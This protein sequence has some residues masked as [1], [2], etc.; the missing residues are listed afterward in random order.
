MPPI[1]TTA[2]PRLKSHPAE[3][4]L[5]RLYTPTPEEHHLAQTATKG[6]VARL[7][8]LLLLKTVQRLGY[9]CLITT[10]PDTIVDHL[11]TTLQ[12]PLT[13]NDLSTYDTSGTRS[14]HIQILRHHLNIHPYDRQTERQLLRHLMQLA[15][16]KTDLTDLI[17]AG[18]EEL[19]R[20]RSEL[21]SF[22]M[23]ERTAR[24]ARAITHRSLYRT[25]L[26]TFDADML[27]RFDRLLF[28]GPT[29]Q[30]T[31]W[32]M[33]KRDPGMPTLQHLQ[34]LLDHLG[35]LQTLPNVQSLRQM[36]PETKL[37]HFADEAASLDAGRLATVM[38][39]KRYTL[40]ATYIIV[41][42]AQTYDDLTT[43]FI[44]RMQSIHR[45]AHETWSTF[46][47]SQYAEA[48][49]LI[50]T[51]RNVVLAYQ[52]PGTT[53]ARLHAIADAFHLQP[54]EIL[55]ACDTQLQAMGR[56]YYP[57]MWHAYRSHRSALFRLLHALPLQ[58]TSQHT[59]FLDA[60]TFLRT[61]EQSKGEW[62]TIYH[63]VQ[64]D[65]G[66]RYRPMISLD[67]MTDGWW[68]LVTKHYTHLPAPHTVHR[69]HFEV[70]IFAHLLAHLQSGD[71]AVIGS[72]AYRD[73]RTQ[74]I[75]WDEYHQQVADYGTMLGFPTT[76]SAFIQHLQTILTTQARTTDAAFPALSDVR[77]E[78]GEPVV[79]RLV[80]RPDPPT[81]ASL[82]T[83]ITTHLQPINILELL[84]LTERWLHWSQPFGL[85]S[86]HD[87]KLDDARSR[88]V[89]TT[90]CY[91]CN[92]GP[93]QTARGMRGLD[94]KQIAW[95]NQRHI[96]EDDLDAAIR[97]IVDA[98]QHLALPK[99]WGSGEHVS[100]DG[101]KWDLYEQNLVAEYHIRYGGYGGIGYYHVSDTYI[102]LFS[103]F[104]PCG[105][106]EAVYILD[107][108]L[109]NESSL[110]P[111]ILHA[112]TQGQ[113]APV[114]AL[115]W[116]LGITLMPRIRNW[117]HLTFFRSH[118][119]EHYEHIDAL[120]STA[121]NW[122]LIETHVPDM[123]RVVLSMQAGK[124]TPSTMLRRLSSYNQHNR[125][126]QSFRELGRVIRTIFLLQYLAD[127][128]LRRMILVALNKGESYHHFLQWL[129]FG[130]E[131][132]IATNDRLAQRK[133]IKY[134]HLV[135]NCTIFYTV[136]AMSHALY[137]L[138][139]AGTPID[140]EALACLSPY[141][142]EHI[143]RF[144]QYPTSTDAEM[145]AFD[146]TIV[147]GTWLPQPLLRDEPPIIQRRRPQPL[148]DETQLRFEL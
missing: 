102:A 87:T 12:I 126:Y 72:E 26:A 45:K 94:R 8:F 53:D 17:N 148:S 93:V 67:W 83:A 84:R 68:R 132:V 29:P 58:S 147:R 138:H 144:G 42:T 46:Q 136:V 120:F 52:Q 25:V 20:I 37:L 62:L 129:A 98:Y 47:Q 49:T 48:M 3:H 89:A 30:T 130:G 34:N 122:Q 56:S 11:S 41:H 14:R 59:T 16:T 43:M 91:G 61:H 18:I 115:A 4:E 88:Y 64:T 108:L 140:A 31:W 139:T 124:L 36:L 114:F 97:M 73:Y 131:R 95:A 123:L 66:P 141:M 128:E 81:A 105:V 55:I 32:H 101:T 127:V 63:E 9:F 77:I 121:I 110:Q 142:T 7:G 135:A 119:T 90:F 22:S 118:N 28:E 54:D 40:I 112:D 70:C 92:L 10:I 78:A 23:L 44:K 24:H 51:L 57:F 19:V 104:I 109:A 107:G 75:S 145:I 111:D 60:L 143:D 146:E 134:N 99:H 39:A 80:R 71:I 76:S 103:H 74:L 85:R 117:K 5:L 69:Q 116:L 33:L 100:A 65:Q 21:P 1:H 38:P 125:L 35:W 13:R 79:A 113:S 137:A 15:M 96:S 133:V 2:Y 27:T 50:A 86:G 6:P 106:W 82:R